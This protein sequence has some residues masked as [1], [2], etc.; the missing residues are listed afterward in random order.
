MTGSP[1]MSA[2]AMLEYYAPLKAFL[3][4][5]NQGKTCGF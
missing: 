4:E 2:A 1:K 5:Q 3:D